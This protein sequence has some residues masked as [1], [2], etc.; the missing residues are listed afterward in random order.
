MASTGSN[1]GSAS[2]IKDTLARLGREATNAAKRAYASVSSLW[3]RK[4]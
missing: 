4:D 1:Q 3:K 2:G